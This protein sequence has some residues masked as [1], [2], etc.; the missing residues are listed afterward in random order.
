MNQLKYGYFLFF[1]LVALLFFP[2]QTLFSVEDTTVRVNEKSSVPT[3]NSSQIEQDLTLDDNFDRQL[4][5]G[6]NDIGDLI[7]TTP[8]L[9]EIPD[10]DLVADL[11]DN[12]NLALKSLAVNQLSTN[13]LADINRIQRAIDTLPKS[14]S[15]LQKAASREQT[16]QD[17]LLKLKQLGTALA[18]GEKLT[19]PVD[20]ASDKYDMA[21]HVI[22]GHLSLGPIIKALKNN[23]NLAIELI[24][25][26]Q[27]FH[28]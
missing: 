14:R 11:T 27:S 12:E 5:L 9:F 10:R 4:Q 6:T 25:R 3:T 23:D 17:S 8:G 19:T 18:V 20:C 7:N 28:D 13:Q 26:S 2:F 24:I 16:K 1:S 15:N 22:K 21:I